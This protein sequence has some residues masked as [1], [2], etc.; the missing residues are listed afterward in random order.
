MRAGLTSTPYISF[1]CP[2]IS[3]VLMPRAY[4]DKILSSNPSKRVWCLPRICGSK[5]PLR[6]R[7]VS[8]TNSPNSPFTV[9]LVAPLRELPLLCPAGSCFSYPRWLVSSAFIAR[10][11]R[12]FVSRFNRPFSPMMS[13]GFSYP[14]SSS[15]TS[16][17]LTFS[18]RSP[19][20]L[21]RRTF[22][23]KIL[24]PPGFCEA[25]NRLLDA[26]CRTLIQ[27]PHILQRRAGPLDFLHGKCRL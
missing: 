19:L 16:S 3:R 4:I 11:N 2:W 1:R 18:I 8:T 10:S 17:G 9:L 22:T 23:Q 24:H 6:S 12:A 25:F 27:R 5:L 15:S 7:G 21:L 26:P 13:S 14:L 20:Q